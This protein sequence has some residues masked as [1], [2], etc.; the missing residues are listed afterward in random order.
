VAEN[1]QR[2]QT[3]VSVYPQVVKLHTELT[4]E[5]AAMIY[6]ALVLLRGACQFAQNAAQSTD[7]ERT[8]ARHDLFTIDRL[9]GMFE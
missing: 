3:P 9:K 1:R 2:E 6:R 4:L 7:E 8:A 5:Q